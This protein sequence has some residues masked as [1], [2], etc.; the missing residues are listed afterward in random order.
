EHAVSSSSDKGEFEIEQAFL[1]YLV[2]RWFNVRAG[3]VIMPVGIVNMLHEPPTFHGVDCPETDT[4]LVP[5]TWREVG[6]GF[7]GAA[8]PPRSDYGVGSVGVCLVEAG[9]RLAWKGLSA[10]AELANVW[11]GDTQRL[12]AL[13]E[14]AAT[15]DAPFQPVSH[16]LR[17][18]YVELGYD[19]LRFIRTR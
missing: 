11:I 3:L 12:N 15:N 4:R 19:V 5:S 18:G 17:G 8:G 16:Q 10:R 14:V 7:F 2:R 13:R 9:L 6:A 1:D